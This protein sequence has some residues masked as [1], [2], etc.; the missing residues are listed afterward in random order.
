[1]AMPVRVRQKAALMM[2][3]AA[4]PAMPAPLSA[5]GPRDSDSTQDLSP[6]E[7]CHQLD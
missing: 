6:E 1:M 5:C 2:S 7:L 4:T 3:A